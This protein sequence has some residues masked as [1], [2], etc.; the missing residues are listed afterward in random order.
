MIA[1]LPLSSR[2]AVKLPYIN[3]CSDLSTLAGTTPN[4]TQK[5]NVYQSAF[6]VSRVNANTQSDASVFFPEVDFK[7][8]R[9]YRISFD[10]KVQ[11]NRTPAGIV[12]LYLATAENNNGTLTFSYDGDTLYTASNLTNAYATKTFDYIAPETKTRYVAINNN[13]PGACGIF[14]LKNFSIYEYILTAPGAVTDVSAT[15]DATG[16]KQ[17]SIKFTAPTKTFGGDVLTGT[18]GVK[19]IVNDITINDI[20]NI[21]PGQQV[22]FT[23]DFVSAGTFTVSFIPYNADGD[24]DTATTSVTIGVGSTK[25]TWL[26][27]YKG[28]GQRYKVPAVYSNGQ[29][30]ISWPSTEGENVTYKVVRYP[31]GKVLADAITGTTAVDKDLITDSPVLYYYAVSATVGETTTDVGNSTFIGLNNK[32]P[33]QVVFNAAEAVN[34]FTIYD[35]DHCNTRWDYNSAY[36]S[37]G[38]SN[39]DE[40]LITPGLKLEPGKYYKL[41]LDTWTSHSPVGIEAKLGLSNSIDALTTEVF[42]FYWEKST[43]ATNHAVFF[44]VDNNTNYFVGIHSNNPDEADNYNTSRLS[45]MAVVEVSDQLPAAVDSLRIAF[46]PLNTSSASIIFTASP[47]SISGDPLKSLSQIVINKD[48]EYFTTIQNPLPGNEYSVNVAVSSGSSS[49]YTI[50]PYNADGEGVSSEIEVSFI[51]P[52]YSQTFDSAS[53]FSGYTVIDGANDGYTW[54]YYNNAARAYSSSTNK[55]F[56]EWLVTPPVHLE[57]GKYYKTYFTTYLSSAPYNANDYNNIALFLGKAPTADALTTQVIAPYT[58]TTT[59]A[60]SVL[61]K[62]YFTVAETGEYYLGFHAYAPETGINSNPVFVDNFNI[63]ALIDPGVPGPATDLTIT[64]DKNGALTGVI[65]FTAPS[66]TISGDALSSIS[67]IVIYRDGTAVKQTS[68]APT[69]GDAL[70]FT[71]DVDADGV[72]LYTVVAFNSNGEG[73]EAEDIAYFGIN[74]PAAPLNVNAKENLDSLGVVTV[75]WDTPVSD[76]DGFPINPDL[77]TYDVFEYDSTAETAETTI[78]TGLTGNSYTF[79]ALSNADTQLFKRFGVRA[80]TTKGGSPGSLARYISVGKPYQLPLIESFPEYNPA[81][82]FRQESV[83]GSWLASWG[84]NSSDP[85]GVQPVDNDEG[86]AIMEAIYAGGSAGLITGKIKLDVE[87]PI[88]TFYVY[89]HDGSNVDRNYLDIQITPIDSINW[90]IIADQTINSWA[91]DLYGWQKVSLDLKE[92]AGKNV[93]LAFVGE[94]VSHRYTL[95]DRINIRNASEQDMAIVNISAPDRV[96]AGSDFNVKVSVKHK[97]IAAQSGKYT[98]TI[99]RDDVAIATKQGENLQNWDQD[100]FSITEKLN[101]SDINGTYKTLNYYATVTIDD[102]GDL[103][104]NISSY[105]QTSVVIGDYPVV[106]DL[107]AQVEDGTSN[108]NLSWN[109]P[110]LPSRPTTITDDIESYTSWSTMNDVIGDWTMVDADG[111][112]VAT[113]RNMTL[114][115]VEIQSKQAFFV[116][117]FALQ[118]FVDFNATQDVIRYKAHSG[119]KVFATMAPYYGSDISNDDWLISPELTGDAQTISF[120]AKSIYYTYPESFEI[121]YST[122][123][124]KIGDFQRLSFAYNIAD[125]YNLFTYDL[126]KGAKYF[127]IRH[128]TTGGFLFL[129]DDITFTP[130]G[131]ERLVIDGYNVFRNGTQIAKNVAT[132]SYTDASVP[133]GVQDYG[134]SIQYNLGES[135]VSNVSVTTSGISALFTDE[136]RIYGSQN[137]IKVV[138]AQGVDIYVY[139]TDGRLLNHVAGQD[140]T[141]IPALPGLYIVK[142]GDTTQKVTVQ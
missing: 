69:P 6:R 73:R 136:L 99:Y 76:Y 65:S 63:S 127:A 83:D 35:A 103:F 111:N 116:M 105:A 54:T 131:N 7:A 4:G 37:V 108:V 22:E 51:E 138:N 89:N 90:K 23:Q 40:W 15:A 20:K 107:S 62:D 97:G 59:K 120:Y 14:Y 114:P 33:Y 128:I 91:Q 58:V 98:I 25:P 49:I 112:E 29:V 84:Y 117:D 132:T 57:A 71:D 45:S 68:S 80:Q 5:W 24:G 30:N 70:S 50:I 48:G 106:T 86:L 53:S 28:G 75:T 124:N 79:T 38:T 139:A 32:A 104:D 12:R 95:I 101:V 92:Y 26:S 39:R 96:S 93:Y 94:A 17:A 123:S 2:A 110:S 19:V 3:P 121:Y 36:K 122:A 135:P 102:D 72:H 47:K 1:V 118:D 119:T 44:K 109:A 55:T 64:P 42:P 113:I 18:L 129:V 74:R 140:L 85:T 46:D 81:V 67:K 61:L 9:L 126:P 41:S 100:D 27:D 10:T 66:K 115:N 56:D 21:T 77:I 31:D 43:V 8:G 125:D 13:A 52:P 78:A 11:Y 87:H 134:V 34:E 16:K 88:L 60:S 137:S 141:S 133:A 142:A 82:I 130:A